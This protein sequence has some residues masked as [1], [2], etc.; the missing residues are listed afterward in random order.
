MNYV[1]QEE[2]SVKEC[3]DV[4]QKEDSAKQF[5]HACGEVISVKEY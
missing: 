4:C 5:E 3:G 1:S 2:F